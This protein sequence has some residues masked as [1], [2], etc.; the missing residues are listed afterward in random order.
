M[1]LAPPPVAADLS[2]VSLV[3]RISVACLFVVVCSGC[4]PLP[5]L[6][7]NWP[8]AYWRSGDYVLI[9]IDTHAQMSLA[10]DVRDEKK[11][12][13]LSVVPA[14]VFS[15]GA[16]D[17]YL[18][19]KQHP[20]L[21]DQTKFDRS[22]TNYFV[23][24]RTQSPTLREP[25]KGVRGPLTRKEFDHLAETLPLPPFSKTFRSLEWQRTRS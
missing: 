12:R 23:V 25:Q 16:N 8:D 22:V 10:A 21:S 1:R 18:I 4:Y 15:V 3:K 6:D 24:D 14:T 19:A 9:A 17:R 11:T 13:L 7:R 5:I 2:F 20:I